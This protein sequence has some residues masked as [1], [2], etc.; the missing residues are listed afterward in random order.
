M[1]RYLKQSLY[2]LLLCRLVVGSSK[3]I[4]FKRA[5]I[6]KQSNYRVLAE[7]CWSRQAKVGTESEGIISQG[8]QHKGNCPLSFTTILQW[9]ITTNFLLYFDPPLSLSTIYHLISPNQSLT[10]P[11]FITVHRCLIFTHN[12]IG[13]SKQRE[14]SHKWE[15]KKG[16]KR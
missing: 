5:S 13:V 8:N 7:V 4:N 9:M 15:T 1:T 11:L 10:Q 14:Q 16:G 2:C 3:E 12:A 6:I